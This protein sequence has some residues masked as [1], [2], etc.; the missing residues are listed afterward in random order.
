[1]S[2]STTSSSPL[3]ELDVENVYIYVADAVR[4][5]H[6]PDSIE[7]RGTT[8]KSVSA[9]THSPPSFSSLVTGKQPSRHGVGSFDNQLSEIEKPLLDLPDHQTRFLNS[10]FAFAERKDD[11][12]VDPIYSVLGTDPP[13]FNSPFE[14]L[15]EP[16]LLIER[17]P[18]GHAPYGEFDG[19]A[20]EYFRE[21]RRESTDKIRRDYAES[22]SMD[23]DLFT[24]RLDWLEKSDLA[25]QTLVIYTSDHGELLEEGGELGHSSPMRPELVYVPTVFIHPLLPAERVEN[26]VVQ[27]TDIVATALDV[28]DADS[29]FSAAVDGTSVAESFNDDP[30]ISLLNNSLLPDWIPGISG[31]LHYEGVWDSGGGYVFVRSPVCERLPVLAGKVATSSRR[32]FIL[33]HLREAL[34]A[35]AASG[36]IEYGSPSFSQSVGEEVLEEA[37]S[38]ATTGKQVSLS[39]EAEQQL[40]DLG[41][42]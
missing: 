5:D 35:Y 8:V 19:T 40:E 41:Y 17:G 9:S 32:Y 14:G 25:D 27:H 15:E 42:R 3:Q 34:R 7:S 22:V 16:F 37:N 31:K 10:I 28:L 26:A 33:K 11:A 13:E 29:E 30:S 6:L 21:N 1:M 39:A 36:A 20:T 12:A 38:E 18:G 4:W 24:E 23:A 2:T